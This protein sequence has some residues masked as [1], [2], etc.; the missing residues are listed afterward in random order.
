MNLRSCGVSHVRAKRVKV[1]LEKVICV[2]VDGI[3]AG[4]AMR[5][6]GCERLPCQEAATCF[7]GKETVHFAW[8]FCD[9]GIG[10]QDSHG[11]RTS[12]VETRCGR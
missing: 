5:G 2:V 8:Y 1:A 3:G 6:E 11:R 7:S 9:G 10:L 4:P 12:R